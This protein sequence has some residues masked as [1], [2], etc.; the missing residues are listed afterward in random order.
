MAALIHL[1]L[2]QGL[3]RSQINRE[4]D[5]SYRLILRQDPDELQLHLTGAS[6]KALFVTL[7]MELLNETPPC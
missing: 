4:A 6:V 3:V 1:N 2:H 5:G 7:L